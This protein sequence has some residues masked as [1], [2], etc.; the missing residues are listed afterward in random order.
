MS[1]AGEV[2]VCGSNTYGQLG[3]G[4]RSHRRV[5]VR[6]TDLH[7]IVSVNC[8]TFHTIVM[9]NDNYILAFGYNYHGTLCLEDSE[10]RSR[11]VQVKFPLPIRSVHCFVLTMILDT[12]MNVWVFGSNHLKEPK[13]EGYY[14]ARKLSQPNNISFIAAG[15]FHAIMQSESNEIWG[16]GS[17]NYCQLALSE[18]NS[19]TSPHQL[20][21]EYNTIIGTAL[22]TKSRQKSAR[23]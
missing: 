4:H 5:P 17:N 22:P 10:D 2:W 14:N 1:D 21:T 6:N 15:G 11:P 19:H 20:P 7:N 8:G 13:V 12:N 16:Y 3:L 23:K 18:D 9:N